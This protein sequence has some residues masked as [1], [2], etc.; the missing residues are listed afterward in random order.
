V[1]SVPPIDFV[2]LTDYPV[3]D[4]ATLLVDCETASYACDGQSFGVEFSPTKTSKPNYLPVLYSAFDQSDKS[5]DLLVC[6]GALAIAQVA[7]TEIPSIGTV[8]YGEEFRGKTIRV[9]DHM[10][11]A[12]QLVKAITSVCD[13]PEALG[14][15]A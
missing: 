10:Q 9:A 6:L 5:D 3:C 14:E 13:A 15:Q 12:R 7:G 11:K 1:L 4:G 8:I 2:S